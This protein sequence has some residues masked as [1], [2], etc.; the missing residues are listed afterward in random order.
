M[1]K[2]FLPLAILATLS[3]RAQSTKAFALTDANKGGVQWNQIQVIDLANGGITSTLMDGRKSTALVKYDNGNADA[4]SSLPT[5]NMAPNAN[6]SRINTVQIMPV[7]QSSASLAYDQQHNRIYFTPLFQMGEIRYM[8]LD[9]ATPYVHVVKFSQKVNNV[10]DHEADNF[11]RMVI[12]SDGD[13][14]AITNDANTFV[15]FTTGKDANVENLGALGDDKNNAVSIHDRSNWG[16]DMIA[17]AF[18]K[19][20]MFTVNNSVFKINPATRVATFLGTIQGLP[21]GFTTNAAAVNSEGTIILGSAIK[22]GEYYTLD[23]DKMTAKIL[24]GSNVAFNV[25]DLATSNLYDQD[26]YNK[27]LQTWNIPTEPAAT[28]GPI[29]VFP[30]PVVGGRVKVIF[31]N[32]KNGDY[33]ITLTDQ[34]GQ[35]LTQRQVT[36]FNKVQN[37][38]VNIDPKIA[39]GIYYVKVN[40]ENKKQVT[41]TSFVVE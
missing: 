15:H 12:G 31:N 24:P 28:D 21:A 1:K 11:T 40:D 25:S 13:G 38:D 29:S 35:N 37:Q 7:G 19:F 5:A 23:L 4:I 41:T 30:N 10:T 2:I 3:S 6:T 8:N 18:G 26:K 14:Y 20:Y 32:V 9:E 22:A 34:A 16:G 17:D 27:S 36:I 33:T 39:R